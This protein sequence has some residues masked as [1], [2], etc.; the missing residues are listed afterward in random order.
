MLQNQHTAGSGDEG[1][2][3]LQGRSGR[4]LY[5]PS[6]VPVPARRIAARAVSILCLAR[7]RARARGPKGPTHGPAPRNK[8]C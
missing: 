3:P 4:A 7:A 8:D 1:G 2:G 5:G 6:L